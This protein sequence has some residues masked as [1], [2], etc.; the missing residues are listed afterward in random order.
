MD[1]VTF[2]HPKHPGY[3]QVPEHPHLFVNAQNG[4]IIN[5]PTCGGLAPLDTVSVEAFDALEKEPPVSYDE[6]VLATVGEGRYRFGGTPEKV[7]QALGSVGD[8][9]ILKYVYPKNSPTE[10]D[11]F[12]WVV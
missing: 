3:I 6:A 11:M 4:R 8:I 2:E 5:D 1:T 9:P 7:R 10:P 12:G